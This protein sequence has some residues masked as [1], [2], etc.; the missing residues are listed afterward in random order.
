MYDKLW[1]GYYFL[2]KTCD[3][4]AASPLLPSPPFV[5]FSTGVGVRERR[6]NNQHWRTRM[7]MQGHTIVKL[8]MSGPPCPSSAAAIAAEDTAASHTPDQRSVCDIRDPTPF[9][10]TNPSE[11]YLPLQVPQQNE[12]TRPTVLSPWTFYVYIYTFYFYVNK[13]LFEA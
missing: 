13:H 7:P 8:R 5:R 4:T 1:K 3:E 10:W 2:L 11:H 6:G 9:I 12:D